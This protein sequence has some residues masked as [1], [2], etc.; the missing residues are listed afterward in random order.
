MRGV[1]YVKIVLK[2]LELD[3]RR[4]EQLGRLLNAIEFLAL[5]GVAHRAIAQLLQA[6]AL[7]PVG[8]VLVVHLFPLR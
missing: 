5:V 1:V 3:R 2:V 7:E 4:R 6:V 8:L